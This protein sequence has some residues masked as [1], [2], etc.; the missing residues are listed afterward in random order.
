MRKKRKRARLR[1]MGL[2][3]FLVV[4]LL[5]GLSVVAVWKGF[6]VKNVNVEGN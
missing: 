6:V 5:A 2:T 4:L 3:V 1:R